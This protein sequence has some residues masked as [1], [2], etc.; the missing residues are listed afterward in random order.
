MQYALKSC[1]EKSQNPPSQQSQIFNSRQNC[2]CIVKGSFGCLYC[3]SR[4]KR[5]RFCHI[6]LVQSLVW[7][8][9]LKLEGCL[10]N[11]FLIGP[12]SAAAEPNSAPKIVTQFLEPSLVLLRRFCLNVR[13]LRM[14]LNPRNHRCRYT[15]HSW[16]LVF[17][18]T[19]SMSNECVAN[20]DLSIIAPSFRFQWTTSP[21]SCS[22][23]GLCPSSSRAALSW[24]QASSSETPSPARL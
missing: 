3:T 13:I 17:A 1:S 23:S 11:F 2:Q 19:F 7:K 21:S 18:N 5:S 4:P 20:V 8:Y 15:L 9:C 16:S 10:H 22:T 6:F 24:S 12:Y 14:S